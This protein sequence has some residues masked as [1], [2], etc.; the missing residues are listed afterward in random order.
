MPPAHNDEILQRLSMLLQLGRL[1]RKA[2]EDE[3]NFIIVNDSRTLIPYR[4]AVLCKFNHGKLEVAAISGLAVLDPSS[5]FLQWLSKLANHKLTRENPWTASRINQNDLLV[6]QTYLG[7]EWQEWLPSNGYWL[8]LFGPQDSKQGVLLFFREEPWTPPEMHVLSYLADIYGQALG[9]FQPPSHKAWLGKVKKRWKVIAAILLIISLYPAKESAL[10]PAEVT[11][12][13]P[14]LVRSSLEGVIEQLTVMPN[15]EI[16][17]GQVLAHLDDAQLRSRLA[18]A[19]KNLEMAR[20]EYSQMLQQALSNPEE[21]SRLPLLK[22]RIEQLSSEAAYVEDLLKRTNII[23]QS[24][25]VAVFDDP[26]SWLGRP[27]TLGEKI[28]LVADPKLVELTMLLPINETLPVE[29]GGEALFFPNISPGSPTQVKITYIS[30]QATEQS[31]ESLAFSLRGEFEKLESLPRL[32]MRG[33]AK[34]YGP[35]RPLA[36]IALRYPLRMLRQ[37][38]GW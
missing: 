29:I 24:D 14:Q 19:K 22:G 1:A 36:L 25:G 32:G 33:T 30:Y 21:K 5:P 11:A 16:K 9:A 10:V 35:R 37:W 18:V 34:I 26:N 2:T 3:L 15:Q 7:G 31:G 27:V 6:D 4:Q 28:M 20:A 23:S 13:N 8:P 38:L 12:R 17:K